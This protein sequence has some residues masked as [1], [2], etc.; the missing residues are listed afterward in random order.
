MRG[1]SA[2]LRTDAARAKDGYQDLLRGVDSA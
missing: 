2:R 1:V